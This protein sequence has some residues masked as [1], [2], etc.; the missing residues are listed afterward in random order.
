MKNLLARSSSQR[1]NAS[2][3]YLLEQPEVARATVIKT[4]VWRQASKPTAPSDGYLRSIYL[5][6]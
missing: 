2:N 4:T 5:L 6:L 1:S 3:D